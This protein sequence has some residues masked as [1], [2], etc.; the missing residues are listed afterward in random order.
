[1]KNVSLIAKHVGDTQEGVDRH[2]R[3]K[4]LVCRPRYS[5]KDEAGEL[6]HT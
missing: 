4:V 1:M 2:H 6:H 5:S 3:E